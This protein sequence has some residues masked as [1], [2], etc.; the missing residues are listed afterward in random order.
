MR[1]QSLSHMDF[2][3]GHSPAFS[4]EV[5]ED[6]TPF[7]PLFYNCTKFK[8]EERYSAEQ[9]LLHLLRL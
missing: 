1:T 5:Q 7:L 3:L 6:H 4:G 2:S 9:A 8:P